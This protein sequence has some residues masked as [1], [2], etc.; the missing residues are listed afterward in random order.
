MLMAPTMGV[1][2]GRE[3]PS[4]YTAAYNSDLNYTDLKQAY[5]T[6]STFSKQVA[7]IRVDSRNFEQYKD[8]RTKAPRPLTNAE[9]EEVQRGQK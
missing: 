8:D 4:T 1:E 3:K 2:F 7:N 6:E 9:M 5:T